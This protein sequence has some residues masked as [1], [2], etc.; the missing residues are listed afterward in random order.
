MKGNDTPRLLPEHEG[1]ALLERAGIPVPEHGVATSPEEAGRIAGSIGFPVV[2]KVVSAQ[3]VHKSDAGGVV[4]GIHS[5]EEAR[6][7]FQSISGSVLEKIPGAKISGI[8]VAK[9]YPQGLELLVGGRTDPAFGKVITIGIGGTLVELLRDVSIRVLPVDRATV[10]EMIDEIRGSRI[11]RGFRGSD[12]LDREALVDAILRLAHLFEKDPDWDEFDINPLILYTRGCIAVDARVY[13]SHGKEKATGALLPY[14]GEALFSPGS[15][16]VIGASSD[17][18]KI[19][20]VVLRNLLQFPGAVYPVNPKSQEILGKRAYPRITEVPGEVDAA[21]IA[22]PAPGVPG[23]LRQ[24]TEKGVKLA[25]ILSSGFRESGDEGAALE[26]EILEIA[27]EGNMRIV[28]PNCLGIILPHINLNTTFDPVS[29][30]DGHIGFISQSGAVVTTIVD[31]S[32]P[33]HI[34]FSMVISVGNQVDLGFVE[35]LRV[36]AANPHTRAI[37][38]YIEE[39]RRGRE[40]LDTVKEITATKPVIALKS[41]SSRKGQR[42][43]ASH[44]GSLAGNYQVYQAA[45][46]QAGIIPVYTIQEAFDVAELLASEGYPKGNRALVITTAGGFAVMASD[47]ADW[48]G[49][50]LPPLP[51]E[52]IKALDEFLPPMWSRE[53]PLDIIGDGG[54]ERYARVFDVLSR[55]QD[56]WDIAV[57]IAVPSAILDPAHLGQE[58]ARFSKNTHKMVIG[59]ILG[60]DSMKS[61]ERVLRERHIPNYREIDGAFRAVGR[62][63]STRPYMMR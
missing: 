48:Y 62:A 10:E 17:P 60:G 40:F 44:T 4:T 3:V 36:V 22:I 19:G 13:L 55:F 6:D 63:L 30:M 46:R 2:M 16:A 28:G 1:M 56:Y 9:Q 61:G 41:G 31:W 42:A 54:A 23:A 50:T 51:E 57:V 29:P 27:R 24:C 32:I 53:N 20:Y 39:I 52:M 14:P 34:G 33:E 18:Q 37:I 21:V 43:A 7:V 8:L 59:C 12:P 11:I 26:N 47:Y 45:F 15:V 38:L 35:Y 49:I 25:I 5:V 58:I